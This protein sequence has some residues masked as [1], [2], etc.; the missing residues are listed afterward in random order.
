M[1]GFGMFILLFDITFASFCDNEGI[2]IK[3]YIVYTVYTI[4][5]I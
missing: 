3:G 5:F 1:R 4:V 2:Q